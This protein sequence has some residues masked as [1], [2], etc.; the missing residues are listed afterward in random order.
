MQGLIWV[1]VQA[2][3]NCSQGEVSNHI[4]I[5]QI[6]HFASA[7][8]LQLDYARRGNPSLMGNPNLMGGLNWFMGCQR[9]GQ[10][11]HVSWSILD[12]RTT[13]VV[14]RYNTMADQVQAEPQPLSDQQKMSMTSIRLFALGGFITIYVC[15]T[16]LIAFGSILTI[17]RPR[18]SF[19]TDFSCIVSPCILARGSQS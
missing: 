8:I 16:T 13:F 5:V 10:I 9:G 12:Y 15:F 18:V 1:I 14:L 17:F 7:D 3:C 2:A 6:T 11:D 19:F 4:N